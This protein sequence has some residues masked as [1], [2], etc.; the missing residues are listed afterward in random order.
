MSSPP[1][2][3]AGV[4]AVE[5]VLVVGAGLLGTSVGL[6]LA[7]AGVPVWL[8]DASPRA[9]AL[10]ADLGAG[11]AGLPDADPTVVVVAVPTAALSEVLQHYFHLYPHTMF[12]DVG[13]VKTQ[14]QQYVESLPSDL[15]RRFVG[16]HPMAGRE[17]SG[18]DAAR[19]DLFEGRTWALT[20]GPQ[21][22]EE[23]LAVV[24][25]L[26]T[27]LG[28]VPVV[29]TPEEHD[30]AVALVSHLPQVAASLVASR[31]ADA[32]GAALQL[33]G[34]GLLDTTRIAASDADMWAEILRSNAGPVRAVLTALAAELDQV[35]S[36]LSRLEATGS[37]P[38][39]RRGA[40]DSTRPSVDKSAALA[41]L[42]SV[43]A[44][45]R[46]GRARI[47]G[48]HG[49]QPVRYAI[50]PVVIPDE[51]GALARL[52]V[53]AGEAGVN[54]EDVAIE[55]SPGQPVGLVELSVAPERAEA[56][57]AALREG[58]WGVH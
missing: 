43:L 31:L 50:V 46:A 22:A 29:L 48:K 34:P 26:V 12:T 30:R 15:A 4:P 9:Q 42:R 7:A 2:P 32:D 16:G 35:V 38:D 54:L 18:P 41:Q 53:A 13:S 51:P 3:D 36:A 58:G 37:G 11:T 55:H 10:A 19:A 28:A 14:L 44:S 1:G 33:A 49:G 57:V 23:V 21:V 56:L 5:R 40:D 8:T 25:G 24:H 17:R 20:P 27:A 39:D 6:G 47:P 45:G 52:F